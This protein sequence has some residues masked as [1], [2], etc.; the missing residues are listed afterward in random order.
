MLQYCYRS[1]MI[2]YSSS[3]GPTRA[4]HWLALM[5][6]SAALS[7]SACGNSGSA[8]PSAGDSGPDSTTES[9]SSSTLDAGPDSTTQDAPGETS[10]SD[11]SPNDGAETDGTSEASAVCTAFDAGSLDP[12]AV[13]AGLEFILSIGH[14]YK[15]HQ[16]SPIDAGIILSGNM[17]SIVDGGS[18]YPPNLT[19]D[20]ATGLG[21]FSNDQI[22]NAILFGLDPTSDDGGTLCPQMPRFGL[23]KGDAGALLTDASVFNVVDFL[24]TLPAVT[25]QVP[26]TTCPSPTPSAPSDAGDAAGD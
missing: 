23:P 12:S 8:P 24:R 3:D 1:V 15:C 6:I 22:A 26:M 20:P 16:S 4:R 18:V 21:C 10:T 2:R 14:C 9:G 17:N 13:D 11:G 19:P 5:G 7:A 25:N